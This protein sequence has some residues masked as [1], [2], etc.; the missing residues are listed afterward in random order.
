M[1]CSKETKYLNRVCITLVLLAG[2]SRLM[3]RW[4]LFP[5]YNIF[6][7]AAFTASLQIWICQLQR[8]LTCVPVRR[9]LTAAA[10]LMIFWIAVRTIKYEFLVREHFLNRYAW[11]LYYIAF[12][13]VPLLMFLS[14]LYIGRPYDQP[15]SRKWKLFYLPAFLLLGCVLTNDL[16]QLAFCFPLGV[17]NWSTTDYVHGPVYFMV[18]LWMAA[19]LIAL[20]V[21]AFV[22]CRVPGKRNKIWV[23]VLPI[24]VGGGYTICIV[25]DTPLFLLE[26]YRV[27]EIGCLTFV[28]FMESLIVLR[29]FPSNDSYGDLWRA[30]TIGAGIMD[31]DGVIRLKSVHGRPVSRDEVE[32]ALCEM[33]LLDDG[34]TILR[35]HRISGGFGYWTKDNRQINRLNRKLAD[36]GDV[37]A[38]ENAML[39]AENKMEAERAGIRQQSELYDSIARY[40]SPQLD[41]MEVLL[42][43][44]SGTEEHFEQTMKYACVLNCYVKRSTNLL[45]LSHQKDRVSMGELCLAIGES[46][47]YINLFGIKTCGTYIGEGLLPGKYLLC[48]YELFETVCETVT[49]GADALLVHLELLHGMISLRMESNM[50]MTQ[51][52]AQA[53]LKQKLPKALQSR[54][55]AG[56]GSISV[57]TEQTTV[58]V[59]CSLGVGGE[60]YGTI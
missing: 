12:I 40:V 1:L 9:Y 49:L 54:E 37:L 39:A 14:V 15:I 33:V 30:S 2:I 10:W 44:A 56:Q 36:T 48:V 34:D 55:L 47:E 38:E 18:V 19:L 53:E 8:R 20:L 28:M 27:P 50:P 6:I 16:H 26:M 59:S 58:Y 42:Q 29:L 24:L 45:L 17:K 57:E 52:P 46:L 21:I 31:E 5:Y 11:Y 4:G 3:D 43:Q 35:S 7:F 32:R 60:W 22:R 13:F 41:R 23:P 25:T 51:V